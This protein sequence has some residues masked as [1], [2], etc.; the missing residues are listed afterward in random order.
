M[1]REETAISRKELQQSR[2]SNNYTENNKQWPQSSPFLH[3]VHKSF[4]H[5][6]HRDAA[7]KHLDK[8][9]LCKNSEKDCLN[10]SKNIRILTL[11]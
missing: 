7:W 5:N 10:N 4:L 11:D 8:N 9:V 3:Q 1:L 6:K 2:R